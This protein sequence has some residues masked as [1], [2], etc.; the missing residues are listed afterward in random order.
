[1][2]PRNDVSFTPH[3]VTSC[4]PSPL[5]RGAGGEVSISL[6]S[7]LLVLFPTA[8]IILL[9]AL[10]I[11]G[12]SIRMAPKTSLPVYNTPEFTPEW[13]SKENSH[14]IPAFSFSDQEG[15]QFGSKE[16]DGKIYVVDFFF[17][18]CPGICPRLTSNLSKVQDAF[19]NDPKVEIVSFSVTPDFDKPAVLN[20]YA[21][22][23]NI[24]YDKWHLLTGDKKAIYTLARQSFFADED[25]G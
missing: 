5:R 23:H 17:T 21:Q 22:S 14:V 11:P 8:I 3:P 20:T 16:L 13:D 25:L 2:L 9:F 1:M 10:F 7:R 18:T 6:I 19:K 4:H 24:N 15:K 12:C